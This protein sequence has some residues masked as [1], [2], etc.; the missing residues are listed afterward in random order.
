MVLLE[1][2]DRYKIEPLFEGWQETMIWS[3]LQGYMGRAW[4]DRRDNPTSARII[5]GDFCFFAGSPNRE[6]VGSMPR[7]C[8][9]D[10]ILMI[11][12]NNYWSRLIEKEYNKNYVVTT[13]Y[14]IKKEPDVFDRAKLSGYAQALPSGYE[15]RRIDKR[16]FRI[17][18]RQKWSADFCSQFSGWPE[19]EK[20]GLGVVAVYEGNPV[21]GASSYTYYNGGIEIEIDTRRD[22]RRKG[23]ALACGARLILE[24]LERGLY[25]SWDAHDKRSVAL[26]EKLG[27]HLDKPYTTYIISDIN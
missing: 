3:C 27:Y 23:L 17:L 10:V 6:M 16:L 4:A 1:Q 7:D 26:A 9:S 8:F 11:P 13:R 20:H 21:S 14:A 19:Y 25:P 12:Q 24:C 5:I 15:L 2:E 18:N 22:H